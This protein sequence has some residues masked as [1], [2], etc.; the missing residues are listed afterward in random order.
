MLGT[1]TGYDNAP[2]GP[3]H[4]IIDDWGTLRAIPGIDIYCPSS[5]AYAEAVVDKVLSRG[6]PAFIRI[7]KGEF[8]QPESTE[9]TVYFE[10]QKKDILLVSYGSPVQTCLKV[11]KAHDD[12]SVL[13][14]NQLRPLDGDV[15]VHALQE[16]QHI[17]VVENHFPSSGLYNS[18]CQ[19]CAEKQIY[20]P[21]KS[22]APP[23]TYNLKVGTTVAYYERLFGIDER[24][25]E[26]VIR[27]R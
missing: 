23:E 25:I 18:L 12:V 2:L 7:P 24:G 5:V 6:K 22:I 17:Y 20:H 26:E 1:A 8:Q 27:S 13:V 14:C 15:L 19:L 9:D 21:L 4:H 10:G 16:H 3:T 11:Q